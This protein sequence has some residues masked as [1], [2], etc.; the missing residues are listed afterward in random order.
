MAHGC[1]SIAFDCK[2]GPSEMIKNEKSGFIVEANNIG[3]LAKKIE[4]LINNKELRISISEEAIKIR[5][6]NDLKKIASHWEVYLKEV[7]ND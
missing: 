5:E 6:K 3:A 1:A 2:T 7:L 4:I